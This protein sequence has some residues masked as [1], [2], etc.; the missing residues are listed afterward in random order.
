MKFVSKT[1][2]PKIWGEVNQSVGQ[3]LQEA[4]ESRS[5]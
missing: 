5:A 2:L 4:K 1:I 3:E